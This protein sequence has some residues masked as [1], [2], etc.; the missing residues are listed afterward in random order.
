MFDP[1][2]GLTH[3]RHRAQIHCYGFSPEQ[4]SQFAFAPS[5]I[6][7]SKASLADD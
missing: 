1:E 6:I 7:D 2:W 3:Y 4:D 5:A